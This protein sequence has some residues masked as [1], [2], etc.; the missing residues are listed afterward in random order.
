MHKTNSVQIY[1]FV[2]IGLLIVTLALGAILD[3][4]SFQQ[5]VSNNQINFTLFQADTSEIVFLDQVACSDSGGS[6]G[7]CG[8]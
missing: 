1:Q 6:G 7:S 8:D 2:F 3:V 5:M 4:Q